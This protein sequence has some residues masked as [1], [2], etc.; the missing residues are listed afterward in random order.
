[1]S[2]AVYWQSLSVLYKGRRQVANT[3]RCQCHGATTVIRLPAVRCLSTLAS[4]RT[5]ELL[6]KPATALT[7]RQARHASVVVMKVYAG[8][9]RRTRHGVVVKQAVNR[10]RHVIGQVTGRRW[11]GS[12]GTGTIA[13]LRHGRRH[14]RRLTRQNH[15]LR[16]RM[17]RRIVR[18][19]AFVRRSRHGERYGQR[20]TLCI[21]R[22][23]RQNSRKPQRQQM[24]G[25]AEN[26]C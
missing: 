1:M 10:R 20:I 2:Q 25:S 12:G 3:N 13:L 18:C 15:R 24:P 6:K 19:H 22:V 7:V 21:S 26:G 14:A 9:L 16:Q 4:R 5:G 23:C 17:E 11:N 8:G